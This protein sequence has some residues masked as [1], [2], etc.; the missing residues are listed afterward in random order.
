[1][2]KITKQS[3]AETGET[4][5]KPVGKKAASTKK[6]VRKVSTKS[7]VTSKNASSKKAVAKKAVE[8]KAATKKKAVPKKRAATGAVVHRQITDA[9]R[10]Q[11]IAEAAYVRAESQGFL[12]DER[13]DWLLAEAEVD[14]LL[15]RAGV[16][17]TD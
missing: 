12:S 3:S 13:D 2:A 7:T 8:T 15:T 16:I 11:M 6:G 5:V 4:A 17:V 10:R 9:E 14:S 1:M